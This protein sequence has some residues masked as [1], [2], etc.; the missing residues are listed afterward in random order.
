MAPNTH[1]PCVY[2]IVDSLFR[3]ASRASGCF[4][5][6]KSKTDKTSTGHDGKPGKVDR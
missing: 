4:T 5:T 3:L 1:G 2:V 6:S